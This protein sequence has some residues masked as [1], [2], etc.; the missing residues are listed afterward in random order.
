MCDMQSV[1]GGVCTNMCGLLFRHHRYGVMQLRDL[2][3][4]GHAPLAL[5]NMQGGMHP[6]LSALLAQQTAAIH[7]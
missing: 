3:T 2:S 7:Q 5:S 4:K 6:N 1:F